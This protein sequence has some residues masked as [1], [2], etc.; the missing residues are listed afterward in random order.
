MRSIGLGRP[1]TYT[2]DKFSNV[3]T[4]STPPLFPWNPPQVINF[5]LNDI[6]EVESVIKKEDDPPPLYSYSINLKMKEKTI[7]LHPE[8]EEKM[9]EMSGLI[10]NFLGLEQV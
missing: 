6:V 1:L 2:F 4:C 7:T 3:L 5:L 10:R 9:K 8:H